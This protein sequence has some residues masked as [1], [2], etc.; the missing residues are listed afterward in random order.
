MKEV[1][2]VDPQVPAPPF[3][4]AGK[5]LAAVTP[6]DRQCARAVGGNARAA[7]QQ[8]GRSTVWALRVLPPL[9]AAVWRLL[10]HGSVAWLCSLAVGMASAGAG[11]SLGAKQAAVRGRE[12]RQERPAELL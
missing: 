10:L 3:R 11:A 9:M 2:A 7:G 12:R 4:L 8:W 1:G 5:E 6:I